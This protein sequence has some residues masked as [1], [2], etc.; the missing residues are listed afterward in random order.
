MNYFLILGFLSVL[1]TDQIFVQKN[2]N[3]LVRCLFTRNL[4][5]PSSLPLSSSGLPGIYRDVEDDFLKL[6]NPFFILVSPDFSLIVLIFSGFFPFKSFYLIFISRLSSFWISVICV[7][8]PN[9]MNLSRVYN[10]LKT[11]FKWAPA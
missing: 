7:Q 9:L 6:I 11:G 1:W 8:S 10:L 2:I 3:L 4:F 5:Y